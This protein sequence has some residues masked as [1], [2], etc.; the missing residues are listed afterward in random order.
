MKVRPV[1]SPLL[2]IAYLLYSTDYAP[3]TWET[4]WYLLDAWLAI[5]Y[6]AVFTGIAFLWRPTGNNTR[7]AMSD[8]LAQDDDAEDYDLESMQRRGP[9]NG[10]AP[11]SQENLSGREALRQDE[12]VFE[13]GDEDDGSDKEDNGGRRRG[14]REGLMGKDRND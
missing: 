14:E 11:P 7:L 6:L 10:M 13:I 8:E 4:R 1:L 12:V 2:L 9:G 3:E 5:L